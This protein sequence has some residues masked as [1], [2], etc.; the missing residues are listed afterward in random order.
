MGNTITPQRVHCHRNQPKIKGK[1]GRRKSRQPVQRLTPAE[2]KALREM[3]K[4][5]KRKQEQDKKIDD[6]IKKFMD[7]FPPNK[8]PRWRFP[9]FQDKPKI[10][11]MPNPSPRPPCPNPWDH[12]RPYYPCPNPGLH[13]PQILPYRPYEI[14]PYRDRGFY[15]PIIRVPKRLDITSLLRYLNL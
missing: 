10:P 4:E 2:I 11:W 14:I 6:F 1:L 7:L 8:Y 15:L 3:L 5:R 12:F 9:F 13:G